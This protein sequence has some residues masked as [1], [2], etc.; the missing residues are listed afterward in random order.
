MISSGPSRMASCVGWMFAVTTS[1]LGTRSRSSGS[2]ERMSETRSR[3]RSTK[4]I[5]SRWPSPTVMRMFLSS[6]RL[7]GTS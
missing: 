3:V 4:R 7:V 2:A 1:A 5:M 6:P